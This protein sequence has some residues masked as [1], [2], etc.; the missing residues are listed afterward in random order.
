MAFGAG[1][2]WS[3]SLGAGG[4]VRVHDNTRLRD[5]CNPPTDIRGRDGR[6]QMSVQTADG[7]DDAGV[8]PVLPVSGG[9]NYAV[10]G[11]RDARSRRWWLDAALSRGNHP[12]S[13]PAM[14]LR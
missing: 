11:A 5:G 12:C 14:I 10:V 7:Q 2:G 8:A 6:S 4:L 13:L 9:A 1:P 3:R